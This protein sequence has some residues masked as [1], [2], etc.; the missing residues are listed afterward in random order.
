MSQTIS[1]NLFDA[2]NKLGVD[3]CACVSGGGI[4][5]LLDA[6]S[7]SSGIKKYF[8]HH[9]QSAGFAAE[10]YSAANKS[11]SIC[12]VTI[13]P[14]VANA[15][16]AAF[17]AYVN[18]VPVVFISGAKRS[19]IKTNYKKYRF[20]YPQDIDTKSV[21]GSVVKGYWE[22]KAGDSIQE[23]ANS[24]ISLAVN[25]RP[26]PVWISVPLDIQ[27]KKVEQFKGK[28]RA[29]VK[30]SL[31]CDFGSA[32]QAFLAR[33][34]RTVILTGS[35]VGWIKE[36]DWFAKFLRKMGLPC[37]TSIGSN[38]TIFGA[39]ENNCGIFGPTGRRLANHILVSADSILVLGSGL[40]ID[41]TGFDRKKFFEKKEIFSINS[42]P[43]LNFLE[44]K[45]KTLIVEDLNNINYSKL[46]NLKT[47]QNSWKKYVREL[48]K[49]LTPELDI[50]LSKNNGNEKISASGFV[51]PYG[52][53]LE[54]GSRVKGNTAIVCGISLD[55]VSVCHCMSTSQKNVKIFV[56]KH[57]GQLGWDLPATLGV[58]HSAKFNRVI[59]VTGDGSIM[60]NLQ[61]L[62]TLSR[63]NIPINIFI[64]ENAGYN[65]I[66]TTQITH[67]DSNLIGSD[68]SD[69]S[70][71]EWKRLSDSFG[72]DFFEIKTNAGV[73]KNLE[74]VL[75]Q[76]KKTITLLRIDPHRNRTPR[77]VSIL[78]GGKFE[79]PALDCQFPIL[80]DNISNQI[81]LLRLN[82]GI[83]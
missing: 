57:A 26:G 8:F 73:S 3:Y 41:I 74:R 4:M 27:S 15:L 82:N 71:P 25:G 10:A 55:V 19:T 48:N 14:G 47:N 13:G 35:G 56:T 63:L 81:Q 78:K 5:Y 6:A 72:F 44:C 45:K 54:L 59:C 69:L 58:A 76:N 37:I 77:L 80:P 42:D 53:A 24:A 16:A 12:L 32:L 2:L 39:R 46:L 18:S 75:N 83:S 20:N 43:N 23:I 34:K 60:F 7:K 52:F 79:T 70:F 30:R 36:E 61:E 64:Y 50:V 29:L 9:E 31:A 68:L 51:D 65:S 1:D 62:A 66:R 67:L 11:P 17:S 49:I 22:I 38:H 33:N 21:V 28:K 40:D